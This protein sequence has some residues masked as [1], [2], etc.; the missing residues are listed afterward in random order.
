LK[1]RPIGYWYGYYKRYHWMRKIYEI[2]LWLQEEPPKW[3]CNNS[4]GAWVELLLQVGDPHLYFLVK[5]HDLICYWCEMWITECWILC[6]RKSLRNDVDI[7]ESILNV[8][9]FEVKGCYVNCQVTKLSLTTEIWEVW[10]GAW[11]SIHLVYV[12]IPGKGIAMF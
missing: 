5:F 12:R 1:E 10:Y 6:K 8:C 11:T 2:N 3:C 4:K 7:M 9:V